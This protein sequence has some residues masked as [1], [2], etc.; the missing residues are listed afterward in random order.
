M[1]NKMYKK[2]KYNIQIDDFIYNTVTG[3]HLS[4]KNYKQHSSNFLEKHG[5]IVKKYIDETKRLFFANR[6][7]RKESSFLCLTIAVTRAC[8]F[9]CIYCYQKN[10][11]SQHMP[12]KVE[13]EII[14]F[15]ERY[16]NFKA[17]EHLEI[18]WFGGEPLLNKKSIIRLSE[19]IQ[20]FCRKNDITYVSKLI[21][22]GFDFGEFIYKINDLGIQEVQV[23][24]D[25]NKDVHNS[26]RKH[27]VCNETFQ[28]IWEN[29]I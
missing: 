28:V 1:C 20:D 25:G 7:T 10:K 2:S 5:F 13:K 4:R 12:E 22:N 27:I 24:L 14:K 18:H 29:I 19:L 17:F 11:K 15:I 9:D 8:D 21:T 6:K 3:K 23:T 26:R 16:Y